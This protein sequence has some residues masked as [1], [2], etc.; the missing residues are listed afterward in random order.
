M[1]TWRPDAFRPADGFT[2]LEALV[3]MAITGMI[4]TILATVIG[5]WLPNW[6]HGF[7]RLQGNEHVA[8]AIDRLVADLSAAEFVS[9]NRDTHL[10]LFE[11]S[12][13]SVTFVRTSL[14][15]N[16]GPGLELIRISEIRGKDGPALVRTRAP[17]LHS[18]VEG[19]REVKF[20]DPVVLLRSPYRLAFSYT[21]A[22][23][24]WHHEWHRQ[25]RLPEAVRLTLHDSSVAQSSRRVTATVVHAQLPIDCLSANSIDDCFESKLRASDSSRKPGTVQ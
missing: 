6:K 5:Q 11:G 18:T 4:I 21:G 3:A 2:L 14:G 17:F 9:A 15:P 1:A 22:D 12:P 23:R 16:S 7:G 25:T 20:Q 13:R 24:V 19:Q 8:I 10:P